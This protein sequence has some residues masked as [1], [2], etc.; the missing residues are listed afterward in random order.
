MSLSLSDELKSVHLEGIDVLQKLGT[1]F[2]ELN[3]HLAQ[4]LGERKVG[5]D[6]QAA[7]IGSCQ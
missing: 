6:D 7:G 1:I 4:K 5:L 3:T 2:T